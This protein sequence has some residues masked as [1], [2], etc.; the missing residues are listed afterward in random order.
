LPLKKVG[1]KLINMKNKKTT[2]NNISRKEALKKIGYYGKYSALTAL[3]TY[4]ILNPQKTQ[5][6]SPPAAPGNNF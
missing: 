4:F 6:I 5:A 1:L 3:A 2:V